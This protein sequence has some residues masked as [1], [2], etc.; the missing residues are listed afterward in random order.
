MLILC[1]SASPES[2]Y[3]P[4]LRTASAVNAA[5]ADDDAATDAEWHVHG[6]YECATVCAA[7]AGCYAATYAGSYTA[8]SYAARGSTSK[9]P[10]AGKLEPDYAM[11]MLSH[12][13]LCLLYS[14]RS[15]H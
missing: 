4:C 9:S 5:E 8:G 13:A 12:C 1:Y 14:A 7:E 10:A 6:R 2:Q 3:G 11:N 15:C